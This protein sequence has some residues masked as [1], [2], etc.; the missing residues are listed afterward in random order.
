VGSNTPGKTLL[1]VFAAEAAV[2]AGTQYQ[3]WTCDNCG[4]TDNP[5]A[6]ILCYACLASAPWLLVPNPQEAPSAENMVPVPTP[7]GMSQAMQLLTSQASNEWHT[8]DWLL[9]KCRVALGGPITTDPAS[10][11][12]AQQTVK[13]L[14]WFGLDHPQ[15][16]HRDG[17]EPFWNWHGRVFLNPPYGAEKGKSR[18]GVWAE[19]LQQQY[20][21]GNITSAILLVNSSHGYDWY[22]RL[23]EKLVVCTLR[24]R[25]SFVRPDGSTPGPAK[26]GQSLFYLGPDPLLFAYVFAPYGRV[27]FPGGVG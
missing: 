1:E 24:E 12:A 4:K 22:E 16:E 11:Q 10:S 17:L 2:T 23:Y 18:A 5:L 20:A 6:E 21:E 15:E 14:H 9:E 3:T 7:A 25:V 13:A 26:R 8:P 19:K 27:L